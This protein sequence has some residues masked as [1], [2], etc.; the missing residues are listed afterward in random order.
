MRGY[1]G[2]N[3]EKLREISRVLREQLQEL[4]AIHG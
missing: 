2:G 4:K 3:R 1:K